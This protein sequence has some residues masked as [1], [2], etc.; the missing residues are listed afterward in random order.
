MD[1]DRRRCP[2]LPTL[3]TPEADGAGDLSPD[4]GSP[5]LLADAGRSD[6]AARSDDAGASSARSSAR[7]RSRAAAVFRPDLRADG[8]ALGLAA[9]LPGTGPRDLRRPR[10]GPGND[11]DLRHHR[12][13]RGPADARAW[14]A[15]G[16]RRV[17]WPGGRA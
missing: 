16:V 4:A 9:T 6:D 2:G 10:L 11:R 15:N 1:D 13:E 7:P 8:G 14:R 12:L 5:K 3:S 17:A